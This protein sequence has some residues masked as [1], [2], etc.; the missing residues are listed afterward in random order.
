MIYYFGHN[1]FNIGFY[2]NFD[3]CLSLVHIY[4]AKISS[5]PT[6][7]HNMFMFS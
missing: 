2:A 5:A 6:Y 7:A 4:A 1:F 3:F